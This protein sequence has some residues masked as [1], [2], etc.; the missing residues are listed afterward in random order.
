M[1]RFVLVLVFLFTS[2][3]PARANGTLNG[4]AIDSATSAP[5]EGTLVTMLGRNTNITYEV[6]TDVSGG[7]T[8]S[9][10]PDFYFASVYADTTP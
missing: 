3:T 7:F 6:L 1:K 9:L 5:V 4:T 10:P 8:Q 2:M